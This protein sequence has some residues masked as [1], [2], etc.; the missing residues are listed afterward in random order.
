MWKGVA[1]A[2]IGESS[3]A[4]YSSQ[5][6]RTSALAEKADLHPLSFAALLYA[7]ITAYRQDRSLQQANSIIAA[8]NYFRAIHMLPSLDKDLWMLQH[9]RKI[10]K[11]KLGHRVCPSVDKIYDLIPQ[12][13]PVLRRYLWCFCLAC[14]LSL[15]AME[16]QYLHPDYFVW[17][18][19][20]GCFEIHFPRNLVKRDSWIRRCPTYATEWIT[21]FKIFWRHTH[22]H[23]LNVSIPEYRKWLRMMLND[24]VAASARHVGASYA[25][26]FGIAHGTI[27]DFL[28]HKSITTVDVYIHHN[29]KTHKT[30]HDCLMKF[31][32]VETNFVLPEIDIA[33]YVA[34]INRKRAGVI[35]K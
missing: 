25:H 26:Y 27:S 7:L 15:R 32:E 28:G 5:F 11:K 14:V 3:Q 12:V 13:N 17:N 1:V 8:H 21:A 33:K 23:P 34:D 18:N 6:N 9:L 30:F 16:L 10:F 22:G 2:S 31:Q 20:S 4:Q 35:T 19:I 24:T 29:W